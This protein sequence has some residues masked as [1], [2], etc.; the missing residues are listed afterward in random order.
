MQWNN[1]RWTKKRWGCC[2]NEWVFVKRQLPFCRFKSAPKTGRYPLF[3]T[4]YP[5]CIHMRISGA[6]A[7]TFQTTDVSA[8]GFLER[9]QIHFRSL[10]YLHEDFWSVC[11]YISDHWCICM[12]IFGAFADTFQTTDVSAWGFLERLQIYFRPLM[13]L[14]EDSW[15]VCRYIS[16]H[17]CICMR[18]SGAF[19]DTFQTTAVSTWGFLERL[20]IHFR[21][22]MYLHE[23]FWSVCR[24]IS[25]HWCICMRIL[26]TFADTSTSPSTC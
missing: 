17:W 26:D 11:G 19:A 6:L 1:I 20:R 22:L 10:M 23:D 8:W 25:D 13:Y 3:E 15:S 7:D 5:R 14:H 2:F 24:Y 18:I 12:R 4:L 21:P 9:L 16:D